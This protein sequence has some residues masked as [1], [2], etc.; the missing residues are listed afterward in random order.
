MTLCGATPFGAVCGREY[1]GRIVCFAEPILAFV[2]TELRQKGSAKRM[3]ALFLTKTT[4]N[5]MYVVGIG[6]SVRLTR[7]VK[8]IYKKCIRNCVFTVGWLKEHWVAD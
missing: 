7:A 4:S 2:G 3:Q 6:N 5:D 8:R 1:D